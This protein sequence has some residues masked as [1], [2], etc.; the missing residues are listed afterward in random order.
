MGLSAIP[1]GGVVH[2]HA[3]DIIALLSLTHAHRSLRFEKRVKTKRVHRRDQHKEGTPLCVSFS[4]AQARAATKRTKRG[5]ARML[6]SEKLHE[7]VVKDEK[8]AGGA[9]SANY[10]F[11]APSLAVQASASRCIWRV[12][13]SS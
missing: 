8:A 9:E 12:R 3:R 7:A 11:A 5:A 4:R 6:Q 1:V 2:T 13:N 10:G